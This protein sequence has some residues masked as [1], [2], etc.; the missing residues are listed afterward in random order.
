[1]S[2]AVLTNVKTYFA[3]QVQEDEIVD[4]NV[5]PYCSIDKKEKKKTLGE[6]KQEFLQALQVL[7]LDL[8][9]L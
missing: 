1:M 5:L 8:Q 4:N 7:F 2:S 9:A 3:C 6:M